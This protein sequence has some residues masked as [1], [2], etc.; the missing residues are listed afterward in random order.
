MFLDTGVQP[1]DMDTYQPEVSSAAQKSRFARMLG[2]ARVANTWLNAKGRKK[3]QTFRCADQ[4]AFRR[5]YVIT[6]SKPVVQLIEGDDGS[7]GLELMGVSIGKVD[8]QGAIHVFDQAFNVSL[9]PSAINA[10]VCS[11]YNRRLTELRETYAALTDG[12]VIELACAHMFAPTQMKTLRAF[13]VAAVKRLN[14]AVEPE[15]RRIIRSCAVTHGECQAL[16]AQPD[17]EMARR[18][19]QAYSQYPGLMRIRTGVQMRREQFVR[20]IEEGESLVA[21]LAEVYH[22]PEAAVRRYRGKHHLSLV[23]KLADANLLRFSMR[24]IAHLPQHLHPTCRRDYEAAFQLVFNLRCAPQQIVQTTKGIKV[25][26]RE[27]RRIERLAGMDD[28][29]RSLHSLGGHHALNKTGVAGMSLGALIRLNQDWH[30]AQ[31]AATLQVA[32]ASEC[33]QAGWPGLLKGPVQLGSLT[34]V[35]LTTPEELLLEGQVQRHCVASYAG[36]CFAGKARIVSLRNAAGERVSTIE[37]GRVNDQVVV[38][39]HHGRRNGQPSANAVAA[40]KSL[41]TLMRRPDVAD[42]AP[43]PELTPRATTNSR[44][45]DDA[46][47]EFW[48]ARFP[49]QA[50]L[51]AKVESDDNWFDDDI[52][53]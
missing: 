14:A 35:E 37:F 45:M 28:V 19:I 53:M 16:L 33:A 44:Q 17:R 40:L 23:S 10:L 12:G 8:A 9:A 50:E 7:L 49:G 43:W 41:R 4:R 26:L 11:A 6:W 22:I 31:L 46:M 32:N 47:R 13:V 38:R 34:A 1:L 3:I 52:P 15:A 27:E 36:L 51:F 5:A 29:Y 30:R 39:Q 21:H 24:H 48:V 42:R 2:T 18:W 25:A 20:P